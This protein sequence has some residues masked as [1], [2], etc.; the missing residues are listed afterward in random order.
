MITD[1][2]IKKKKSPASLTLALDNIFGFIEEVREGIKKNLE[3][4]FNKK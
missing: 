4:T 1:T 3:K 2:L